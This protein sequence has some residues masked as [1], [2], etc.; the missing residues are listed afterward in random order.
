MCDTVPLLFADVSVRS[1]VK[2][3][4]DWR[5]VLSERSRTR[6][7]RTPGLFASRVSVSAKFVAD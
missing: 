2:D 4:V 5:R 1:H 7:A 6:A 3:P